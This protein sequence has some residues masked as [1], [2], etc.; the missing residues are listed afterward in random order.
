MEYTSA[1]PLKTGES[2]ADLSKQPPEIRYG[3]GIDKKVIH[4]IFEPFFTT[5]PVGEGTGMGLAM[6][7]GTLITHNGWI[8][9]C[10]VPG[11]GAAFDMVI[12]ETSQ[13]NN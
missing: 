6:A 11:A 9:C 13:E 10:N 5:K 2:A 4:R 7:Y 8:Q 3:P 1:E 12:P